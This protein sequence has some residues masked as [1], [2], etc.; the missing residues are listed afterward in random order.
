MKATE[1]YDAFKMNE[2][3]NSYTRT[4]TALISQRMPYSLLN[5]RKTTKAARFQRIIFYTG[6][7]AY[8]S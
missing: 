3:Q 6:V 2:I 4:G 5:T 8:A 1:F 7:K